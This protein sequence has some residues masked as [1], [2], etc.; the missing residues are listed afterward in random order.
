MTDEDATHTVEEAMERFE[1]YD[2]LANREKT[3]DGSWMMLYAPSADPSED[4]LDSFWDDMDHLM[5]AEDLDHV[6]EIGNGW[7]VVPA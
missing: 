6:T 3:D 7:V 5:E 4:V 1:E 2:W